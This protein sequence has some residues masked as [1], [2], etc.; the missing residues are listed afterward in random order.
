ME[1]AELALDIEIRDKLRDTF[2]VSKEDI[3]AM[4]CYASSEIN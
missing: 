4:R 2:K 1:T 3:D